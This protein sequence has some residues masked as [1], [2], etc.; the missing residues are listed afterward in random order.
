MEEKIA[1]IS[2]FKTFIEV[3][4]G[5]A[6]NTV[7]SYLR[8][9]MTFA[10]FAGK[11]MERVAPRDIRSWMQHLKVQGVTNRTLSRKLSSLRVFYHFLLKEEVIEKDPLV[12]IS[13]P[14]REKSI[15]IFLDFTEVYTLLSCAEKK[16]YT[17]KGKM[18]YCIVAILY[19]CGLRVSELTNLRIQDI[20]TITD[21]IGF[22]IRGKGDKERIV[23]IGAKAQQSLILWRTARPNVS[24]DFLFI[25]PLTQTQIYPR[26]VQRRIKGLGK[27][28]GINK[29]VTPHKLRHTFATHLLHKG[30]DIINIQ[31]LLGHSSLSTTQIYTHT[32]IQ[33]LLQAVEKL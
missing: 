15:P 14:K 12:F 22:R 31:N 4:K 28:A 8:D 10:K 11:E 26:Y 25:H 27:E 20:Q 24:N 6:K 17:P 18:D 1:R 29:I 3:E 2:D 33:R 32:N 13:T 16:T 23:P 21:G 30:E 19:Y 5:R 9:I 7:L